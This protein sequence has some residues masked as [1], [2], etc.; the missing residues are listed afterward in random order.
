[1]T[2]FLLDN[3]YDRFDGQLFRQTAGIPMGTSCASLLA[4]LF[5]YSCENEFLDKLVKESKRKLARKLN[6]SSL[7]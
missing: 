7:H 2:E 1:M 3:I 4:D 5:L 6:L